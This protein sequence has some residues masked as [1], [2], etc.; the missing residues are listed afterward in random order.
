MAAP[1][2][3][4][5]IGLREVPASALLKN[6]NNWRKHPSSQRRALKAALGEIGIADALVARETAEGLELIDGHLRADVSGDQPVPVLVLDVTDEEAR[7]LLATLDPLAAMAETDSVALDALVKSVRHASAE[8]QKL[9]ADTSASANLFN[10]LGE[11]AIGDKPKRENCNMQ[12][13]AG[14]QGNVGLTC[15]DILVPIPRPLY[16]RFERLV[17][18]P[19]WSDRK[20]AVVAV[21]EAGLD[22]VGGPAGASDEGED[23]GASEA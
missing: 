9:L 23:L 18:E 19:R 12:I 11:K 8:V 22:A 13:L 3:N 17:S 2:R 20:G 4:R 5:I 14:R 15:G 16:E 21:I 6:P 1:F 7:V 10:I